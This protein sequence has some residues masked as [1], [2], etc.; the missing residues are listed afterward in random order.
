MGHVVRPVGGGGGTHL[1]GGDVI[2][3]WLRD[4]GG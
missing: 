4:E 2:G 1:D 3:R